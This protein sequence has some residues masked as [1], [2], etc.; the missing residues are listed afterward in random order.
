MTVFLIRKIEKVP[1]PGPLYTT[2]IGSM[3][4]QDIKALLNMK[5][6]RLLDFRNNYLNM[7]KNTSQ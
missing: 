5:K 1:Q 4:V 6:K 3:D 7:Y 2:K